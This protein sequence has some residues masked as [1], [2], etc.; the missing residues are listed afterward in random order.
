MQRY[1]IYLIY[2]SRRD[3]LPSHLLIARKQYIFRRLAL[4]KCRNRQNL[5]RGSAKQ[6][7]KSWKSVNF[8][9]FL[10]WKSVKNHPKIPW[11]NVK[12]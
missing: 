9:L 6:A 8:R 3:F 4:K 5:H 1:K 2:T 12:N 10:P 11:K 7:Q